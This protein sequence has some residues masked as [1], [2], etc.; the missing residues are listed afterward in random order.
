MGRRLFSREFKLEAI[1]LVR[2]RGVSIVQASRDLNVDENVL[3]R[4]IR[5]F[6]SQ[7]ERAFPGQG[8]VGPEQQKIDR[9][10]VGIS[11]CGLA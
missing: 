11:E 4:W 5:E 8:Q 6:S 3:Q 7:H 9:G 2:K 1:R 10:I